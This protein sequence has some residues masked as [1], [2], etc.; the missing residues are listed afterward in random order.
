MI[1]PVFVFFLFWVHIYKISFEL[2]CKKETKRNEPKGG[3]K[4]GEGT[5]QRMEMKERR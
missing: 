4:N 3:E 5:V 1:I 2:F